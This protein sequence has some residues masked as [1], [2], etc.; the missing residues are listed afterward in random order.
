MFFRFSSVVLC[1]SFFILGLAFGESL[2]TLAGQSPRQ[3]E[4]YTVKFSV[5]SLWLSDK[6]QTNSDNEIKV[7][8]AVDSL[9]LLIEPSAV[10]NANLGFFV[11]GNSPFRTG[12]WIA[13][14]CCPMM[15][16]DFSTVMIDD[17][18]G[19]R[20]NDLYANLGRILYIPT[21][22]P[23]LGGS[24]ESERFF[25]P[26]GS[27]SYEP[28]E[29]SYRVGFAPSNQFVPQKIVAES[30]N[31]FYY[32]GKRHPF[33]GS[34][35]TRILW[36][37]SVG[38]YTNW[39][40]LSI[41]ASFEYTRYNDVG[42]RDKADNAV[43]IA[44]LFGRLLS[45]EKGASVE[46]ESRFQRETSVM[47]FRPYKELSGQPATYSVHGTAWPVKGSPEYRQMVQVSKSIIARR[48]STNAKPPIPIVTL[49]LILAGVLVPAV[50]IFSRHR[51][52]GEKQ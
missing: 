25:I 23:A 14:G 5:R 19:A 40:S 26:D 6:G 10:S 17:S 32:S 29:I 1:Y 47:D 44:R 51:K 49:A 24:R 15:S 39:R 37:L 42:D 20:F 36:E 38:S 13:G 21:N 43:P 28:E 12:E 34:T 2:E 46:L 11:V 33:S 3:I 35:P 27:G 4:P 52:S 22:H 45:I 7:R 9:R 41:P 31:Y 50:I 16:N 18:P 48:S 30:P 8:V